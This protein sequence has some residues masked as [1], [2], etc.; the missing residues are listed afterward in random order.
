[1]YTHANP[2]AVC[3]ISPTQS[4]CVILLYIHTYGTLY[5]P[6]CIYCMHND[7]N[8]ACMYTLV[9]L[10]NAIQFIDASHNADRFSDSGQNNGWF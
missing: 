4:V 2:H 7:C 6:Y 9:V 1:M 5:T 3:C 10:F 8:I